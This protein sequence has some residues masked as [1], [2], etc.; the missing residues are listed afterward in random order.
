VKSGGFQ[1][2]FSSCGLRLLKL[3]FPPACPLCRRTLPYPCHDLFCPDC[4]TGIISLPSA[5]CPVCA[6][7]F[8]GRDNSSHLCGRCTQ[9]PPEYDRVFAVGLYEKSLR[10]AIHQFK[11]N[12]RIGLDRSLGMLLDRAVDQNQIFDLVIPVPLSPLRLRQRGYNQSLLLAREFAR[13][14]NIP[15]AA[16]LLCKI[17]EA[18]EQHGLSARNRETNLEGAF[19]LRQSLSGETVLLVDDVLTTGKTAATCAQILKQGGAGE[20]YVAVIARAS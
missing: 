6:L 5:C 8:V 3:I 17:R 1:A 4:L 10:Q 16:R 9:E 20:I 15:V 13:L 18:Q 2:H 7:P 11:F 14:R 12:Q 19:A